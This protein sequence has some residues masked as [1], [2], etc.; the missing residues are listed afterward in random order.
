[1]T[2][3]LDIQRVVDS[4]PWLIGVAIKY[5]QHGEE[6]MIN[7]DRLFHMAS[8]VK[9]PIMVECFRQIE[10][11]GALSLDERVEL[12]DDLKLSG[13]GVLK[14]LSQGLKPT[15][16]DLITLMIIISDN[17][18]TDTI[19]KRIGEPSRVDATMK[20]LG[21]DDMHVKMSIRQ[22]HWE[23]GQRREPLVDPRET[24]TAR[25]EQQLIMDSAC[26]TASP[27]GNSASPRAMTEL[28]CKI[29]RGELWTTAA[30]EKMMEI[31]YKQQLNSRIPSKL[32]RGTMVAHKDGTITGVANDAGVIEIGERNYCVVT[33]FTRD[34]K[35]VQ[36]KDVLRT[37]E[38]F[39]KV[40]SL[41]GDIG[42]LAY[43]YGKHSAC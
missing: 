14:F 7:A 39:R 38:E 43:N 11:D 23:R 32:P 1:M 21:F 35:F 2:L 40:E 33:V 16:E 30:C 5:P 17:T 31:M 36:D 15:I 34:E 42:L 8:V 22:A 19:L 3:V 13:T 25:Q 18:A 37:E 24:N 9:V 10:V 27:Q 26:Y 4:S 29:L 28:L 41:M 6:V 20:S 12:V